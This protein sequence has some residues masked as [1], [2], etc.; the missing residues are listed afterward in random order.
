MIFVGGGAQGASAEVRE[1]AE[2]LGAPV[3]A[4]W[5]GQGVMDGRSER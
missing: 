5:M 4:G 3:V 1:L 2:R